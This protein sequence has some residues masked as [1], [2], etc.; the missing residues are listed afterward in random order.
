MD[1]LTQAVTVL[2]DREVTRREPEASAAML[3]G[4]NSSSPELRPEFHGFR[5]IFR[6][7]SDLRVS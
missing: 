2:E 6:M 5:P 4:H 1:E 7:P 3:R